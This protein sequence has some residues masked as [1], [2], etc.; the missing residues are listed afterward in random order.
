MIALTLS[1]I[2]LFSIVLTAAHCKGAFIDGVFI[3]GTDIFG[4]GSEF[5]EVLAELPHPGYGT[6]RRA[7]WSPIIPSPFSSTV[8]CIDVYQKVSLI[9]TV[10]S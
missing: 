1:N 2:P 10:R 4:S 7:C 9:T 8:T 3:G 6:Y 5:F